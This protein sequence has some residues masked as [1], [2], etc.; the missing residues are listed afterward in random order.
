[1]G[2]PRHRRCGVCG[3]VTARYSHTQDAGAIVLKYWIPDRRNGEVL[4]GNGAVVRCDAH[5]RPAVT[6]PT[7]EGNPR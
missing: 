2:K 3:V 1:M 5:A 4:S 7:R 6:T